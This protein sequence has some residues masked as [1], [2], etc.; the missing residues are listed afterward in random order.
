MSNNILNDNKKLED[1]LEKFEYS[2]KNNL[3]TFYEFIN[4]KLDNIEDNVDIL[5][6]QLKRELNKIQNEEKKKIIY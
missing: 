6:D 2:F 1:E 4:Y 3:L 5:Y